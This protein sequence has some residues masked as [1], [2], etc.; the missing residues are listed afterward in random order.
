LIFRESVAQTALAGKELTDPHPS[1]TNGFLPF[2]VLGL[3][4]PQLVADVK[5]RPVALQRLLRVPFRSPNVTD[6][7]FDE[8]DIFLSPAVVGILCCPIPRDLDRENQFL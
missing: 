8:C 3:P 1:V 6:L 7:V 4:G 5:G 2:R